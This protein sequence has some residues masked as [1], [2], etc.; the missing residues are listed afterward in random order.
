[1]PIFRCFFKTGRH[2]SEISTIRKIIGIETS[3]D[4]T[5]SAIVEDGKKVLSSIVLSSADTFSWSGGV[6]PEIAARRQIESVIPVISASLREAFNASKNNKLSDIFDYAIKEIDA[7]AVTVGPG[8]IGSLL[9]GVE[10]AK[11]LSLVWQKPIIPVNHLVA[12]IYANWLSD[13]K[14]PQFPLIAL[15]VSGGHTDFVLMK[16]HDNIK[17][18]GG[19]RD[20]AAGEAFDKTARLLGL[21]Y[22]G[23]PAISTLANKF[24]NSKSSAEVLN[25]F[26][27][28]M[29]NTKRLNVSFSGLKTAA[30]N[31]FNNQKPNFS[32]NR[33]AAE[34]QEAIVDSLVIKS[35]IAVETY[36]PKSF[37]L[38]GGVSANKRLR[39]KISAALEKK[40]KVFIPNPK[41]TTD[42]A[43][44][45]AG[46]AFYNP[47]P[48]PWQDIIANPSLSIDE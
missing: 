35:V 25:L 1:M 31:Y 20:D 38:A 16:N 8:L 3:C 5:A 24:I 12:H 7:I 27:R 4:E 14:T 11:T 40:T 41:Y 39:E 26:P 43:A 45:I 29:A 30:K 47:K 42:N 37:L 36:K 6:I 44:M 46:A 10:T 34:I 23:G 19:T 17:Y 9:I 13:S 21:P 28:P 48:I 18:L 22:P 2:M 15:V 33:L 32:V